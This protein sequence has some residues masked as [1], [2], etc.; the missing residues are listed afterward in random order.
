MCASSSEEQLLA[1]ARAWEQAALVE[2]YDRYS[3][4][5]YRLALRVLGDADLAE[6]CVAETFSRFLTALR[7]GRGPNRHL[8]GYLYRIAHNWMNDYFRRGQPWPLD[9]E[10][11]ALG[12][13]VTPDPWEASWRAEALRQAMATLPPEQRMVLTLRF[14][15]GLR[16]AEVAD[17]MGKSVGAVKVLQ[18]RAL[19]ALRQ[20]LPGF[21]RSDETHAAD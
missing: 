2:I 12:A 20:R 21:D 16:P 4:Q 5:I 18:H 11:E 1:R 10:R 14:L 9:P 15:E 8:R 19:R 3:P 17:I 6:E 7:N 13:G